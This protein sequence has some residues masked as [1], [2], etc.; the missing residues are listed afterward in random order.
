VKLVLVSAAVYGVLQLALLPG[1]QAV[2]PA[3]PADEDTA[4]VLWGGV[5]HPDRASLEAW[6]TARG[7]SYELWAERHPDAAALLEEQGEVVGQDVETEPE[8]QAEEEPAEVEAEAEQPEAAAE[9][10]GGGRLGPAAVLPGLVVLALLAAAGAAVVLMRSRRSGLSVPRP[11]AVLQFGET[12]GSGILIARGPR[13]WDHS[14]VRAFLGLGTNLGNREETLH[15][16]LALLSNEPEVELLEVSAFRETD[17]VGLEEQPQF[18]NA[19][20]LVWTKLPPHALLDRLLAIEVALGRTR[21]GPRFGPRTIDVDLLL[22]GDAVLEEP[23]LIVPHP[24]LH[25][26]RFALEPL[27]ELDPHVE[28][29][30]HGPVETLLAE[31]DSAS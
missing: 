6:L 10:E 14:G 29:P 16:A 22:Y 27:A 26:R 1:A 17:P 15:R 24:R 11:R 8:A 21:N 23:G 30:G 4:S 20:A 28:I 5:E 7:V 12:P 31:L 25:E 2:T 18:L 19:A 13:R 9:R 3:P